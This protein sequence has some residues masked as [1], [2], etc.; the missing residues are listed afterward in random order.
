[1]TPPA[2]TPCGTA[3]PAMDAVGSSLKCWIAALSICSLLTL[4]DALVSSE[5]FLSRMTRRCRSVCEGFDPFAV[6][7]RP[8][9]QLVQRLTQ[10]IDQALHVVHPLGAGDDAEVEHPVVRET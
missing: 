6:L 4:M 7:V 8:V 5:T 3:K 10:V 1:R 9:H 2:G